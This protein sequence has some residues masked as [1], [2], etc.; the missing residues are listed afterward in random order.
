MKDFFLSGRV[1]DLAL[2]FIVLEAV[3]LVVLRKR[4]GRFLQPLDLFGH[5][6]AGACLLLAVR[7]A[8][9]GADFWWF[10]IFLTASLPAHVF[11]LVRRARAAP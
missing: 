3:L 1:I 5:L 9:T 11:D 2:A 6:G 10:A 4:T 8:L 7:A